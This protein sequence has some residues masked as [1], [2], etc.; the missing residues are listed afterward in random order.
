MKLVHKARLSLA[1]ALVRVAGVLTGDLLTDDDEE[2]PPEQEP[3][4]SVLPRAVPNER[5]KEML[6]EGRPE[7][8]PVV[9]VEEKP[10]RGSL[11]ARAARGSVSRWR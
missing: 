6:R 1:W 11:R 4:E 3:M 10:L 9:K 8:V 5:A 2:D 7:P